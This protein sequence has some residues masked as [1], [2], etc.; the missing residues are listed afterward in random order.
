MDSDLTGHVTK[1]AAELFWRACEGKWTG[2]PELTPEY[3]GLVGKSRSICAKMLVVG[4]QYRVVLKCD[5]ETTV[6]RSSENLTSE[7]FS[8]GSGLR[9]HVLMAAGCTDGWGQGIQVHGIQ[10]IREDVVIVVT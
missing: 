4:L 3:A 2:E 7:V 9:N 6:V 8:H 5:L 10:E 1:E